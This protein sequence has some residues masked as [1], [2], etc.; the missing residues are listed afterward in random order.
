VGFHVERKQLILNYGV[1]CLLESAERII[2]IGQNV[3]KTV[4]LLRYIK[5]TQAET[6]R[7]ILNDAEI[8]TVAG[9]VPWLKRLLAGLSTRRPV[10]VHRSV[11]VGFMA[12]KVALGHF[13]SELFGFILSISFHCGYPLSYIIWGM[14]NRPVRSCSS[15]I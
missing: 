2:I 10:F 3:I 15:E 5:L 8:F 6:P 12:N 11:R 13:V 1:V 7:W 9:A 14:N 4:N